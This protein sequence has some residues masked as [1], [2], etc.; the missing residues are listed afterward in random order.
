MLVEVILK[1]KYIYIFIL[2]IAVVCL[3]SI[4]ALCNQC[5]GQKEISLG[6]NSDEE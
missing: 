1:I 3:F 6:S 5:T 2:V 4:S